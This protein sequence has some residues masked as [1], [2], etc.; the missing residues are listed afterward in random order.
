[1]VNEVNYRKARRY[2]LKLGGGLDLVHDAFVLWW[3]KTKKSLFDEPNG[4]MLR[5]IKNTYYRQWDSTRFQQDGV[6]HPKFFGNIDYLLDS[7]SGMDYHYGSKHDLDRLVLKMG[8]DDFDIKMRYNEVTAR[9]A[10]LKGTYGTVYRYLARGFTPTEIEEIEGIS[11]SLVWWYR[12][13]FKT[14]L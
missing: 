12:K 10:K 13:Q 6:R 8:F 9:G 5:I 2:A 14:L 4:K 11:A 3:D 7:A 1:M